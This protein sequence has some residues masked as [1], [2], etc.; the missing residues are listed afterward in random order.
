MK[1]LDAAFDFKNLI[2]LTISCLKWK[3]LFTV[4]LA[5]G[6]VN[7]SQWHALGAKEANGILG[8][9]ERVVAGRQREEISLSLPLIGL[10]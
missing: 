3:C 1:R 2:G 4:P 7:M 6:K 10:H 5:D 8:C 9:F